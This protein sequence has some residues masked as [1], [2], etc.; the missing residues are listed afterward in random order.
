MYKKYVRSRW[1]FYTHL[2][3]K[4]LEKCAV[5]V[6]NNTCVTAQLLLLCC[7]GCAQMSDGAWTAHG[8]SD[9]TDLSQRRRNAKRYA[10]KRKVAGGWPG[11]FRGV[12]PILNRATGI[13]TRYVLMLLAMAGVDLALAWV[14]MAM[15]CLLSDVRKSGISERSWGK[16]CQ[17]RLR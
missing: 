11:N 2:E 1:K 17:L 15:W 4:T 5:I 9:G 13:L 10:L 7:Q 16:T 14:C 12:C 6:Y 3:A 8:K